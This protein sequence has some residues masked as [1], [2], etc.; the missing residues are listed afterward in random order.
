MKFFKVAFLLT[1]VV[2]AYGMET[3]QEQIV[4]IPCQFKSS[5]RLTDQ[6]SRELTPQEKFKTKIG[7]GFALIPDHPL[8]TGI[9][10]DS[11]DAT[12]A[13]FP[14]YSTEDGE[15]RGVIKSNLQF[16]DTTILAVGARGRWLAATA[17]N[18][19]EVCDIETQKSVLKIDAELPWPT[20]A[21]FDSEENKLLLSGFSSSN[22][23]IM[24]AY[25][26]RDGRPTKIYDAS[27]ELYYLSPD[28]TIG[29]ITEDIDDYSKTLIKLINLH[30]LPHKEIVDSYV[31]TKQ[32]PHGGLFDSTIPSLSPDNRRMALYNFDSL[33]KYEYDKI[34][35][36]DYRENNKRVEINYGGQPLFVTF[37]PDSAY[38]VGIGG[39][40]PSVNSP[41]AIKVYD[42]SDG[43]ETRQIVLPS[44]VGGIEGLSYQNSRLAIGYT[45][46][47]NSD[48]IAVRVWNNFNPAGGG[49][50]L[51]EADDGKEEVADNSG[52]SCSVQ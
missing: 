34:E 32:K 49:A 24:Y 46:N 18:Q 52:S 13:C 29:A 7:C 41:L 2:T 12:K 40:T 31:Y 25:D 15:K 4:R 14:L 3:D 43:K 42:A 6:K 22:N 48:Y 16:I 20:L 36:V 9:A 17:S 30:G 47:E 5:R 1:T 37:S 51:A 10:Q 23:W 27:Q 28:G 38:V 33:G 11:D 39:S 35:V 44:Q 21:S 50:D 45:E 8:V 19:A 26:I